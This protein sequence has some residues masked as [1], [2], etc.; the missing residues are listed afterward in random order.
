MSKV[1][2][3]RHRAPRFLVYL[4][5]AL[6]AMVLGVGALPGAT[7]PASATTPLP[8]GAPVVGTSPSRTTPW[9]APMGTNTPETNDASNAN[10]PWVVE[11]LV[12][13]AT[14]VSIDPNAYINQANQ[15]LLNS[16]I[17]TISFHLAGT[18][19]VAYTQAA[20]TLTDLSTLTTGSALSSVRTTRN[21][22][23]A[24]VTV[25]MVP[26]ASDSCGRANEAGDP[27]SVD[28]E[29]TAFAVVTAD[30]SRCID[31]YSFAH[32]LGHLLG[33][34]HDAKDTPAGGFGPFSYSRGHVVTNV[35]E[36]LMSI[37]QTC[38]CRRELQYSSPGKGFVD[39]PGT[40]SG[41]S[42]EDN[43]RSILVVAPAAAS[44]RG[45]FWDVPAGTS[46]YS[47]IEW[48]AQNY[49]TLGNPD[50]SFHPA[51]AISRGAV[52]AYLYRYRGHPGQSAP[53][54]TSAPFT[55]VPV[56][57]AFCGEIAWMKANGITTGYA[58]GSFHPT[59]AVNRAAMAAYLYRF[60]GH[61]N[62]SAPPCTTAPFTDVPVGSAFCGEIA[63]MKSANITTGYADGSYQPGTAVQRQVAATFLHRL[64]AILPLT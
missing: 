18:M 23:G 28:S 4:A 21:T 61:P 33:A 45:R 8:E 44:Y 42:G 38:N 9:P 50:G 37:D 46:F 10:H 58:D 3:R 12:A 26:H 64:S 5:S 51:D 31:G 17:T 2:T 34:N 43:A 57:S 48:L 56:G 41:T 59:E 40:P 60:D 30:S 19:S 13:T 55:D 16:N 14:G 24:D 62:A 1:L 20:S 11:V 7:P 35:A 6:G 36:D 63:W 32:E 29:D 53:A 54:C 15:A 52:A 47:D 39:F 49:I 25:L 22:I 27:A